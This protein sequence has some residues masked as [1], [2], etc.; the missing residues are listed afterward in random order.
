MRAK[1]IFCA[2][3]IALVVSSTTAFAYKID[4]DRVTR[5]VQGNALSVDW[6]GSKLAIKVSLG[7]NADEMCFIVAE[8]AQI[9]RAGENISLDDILQNDPVTVAYYNASPGPLVAV[10]ITDS[11]D[12]NR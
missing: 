3:V 7:G 5:T 8:D 9:M 12:A 11:N 6:V 1:S 2:A 10:S 4:R